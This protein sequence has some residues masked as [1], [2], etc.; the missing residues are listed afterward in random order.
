MKT[1]RP[2]SQNENRFFILATLVAFSIIA[3]SGVLRWRAQ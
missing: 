1:R 2:Q 3:L